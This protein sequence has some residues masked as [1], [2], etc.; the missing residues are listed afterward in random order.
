MATKKDSAAQ[1]NSAKMFLQ[2]VKMHLEEKG[3]M[4]IR[5]GMY[6]KGGM[7]PASFYLCPIPFM[8]EFNLIAIRIHFGFWTVSLLASVGESFI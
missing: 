3:N 4:E 7:Y 8:S 2:T 1:L 5:S 6:S